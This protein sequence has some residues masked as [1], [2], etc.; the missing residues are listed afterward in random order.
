MTFL[1][2]VYLII[3]IAL[4]LAA[5]VWSSKISE[6]YT[7]LPS[8]YGFDVN[9]NHTENNRFDFNQDWSGNVLSLSNIKNSVEQSTESTLLI[10]SSFIAKSL[11]GSQL[12]DLEQKYLVDRYTHHD[13]P[14]FV[15]P[16]GKSYY[17]FPR[18]TKKQSYLVWF[19]TFGKPFT[20]NYVDTEKIN[21]LTVYHF[22]GQDNAIDDTSGYSF[23]PLVPEK[24]RVLSK[25]NIDVFVEPF[26]GNV[27][28]YFDKGTSYYSD[29]ENHRLWDISQWS[30]EVK[31]QSVSEM[32]TVAT[33]FRQ[34]IIL[35]EYVI[36]CGLLVVGFFF[37]YKA[38]SGRKMVR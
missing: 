22:Q 9:L 4:I 11:T 8:N 33:K 31:D 24:Y 37:V 19:G 25:A 13:L 20:L 3:G 16:N 35:Q 38:V 17:M 7:K 30:N 1:K 6:N 10:D 27:I 15:D 5:P 21:G 23:L 34:N 29:N 12:F 28:N 26:S 18:H 32:A 14:G 2:I 36:P